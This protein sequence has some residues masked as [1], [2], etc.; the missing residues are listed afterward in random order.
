MN[1]TGIEFL[2]IKTDSIK[3]GM[4]VWDDKGYNMKTNSLIDGKLSNHKICPINISNCQLFGKL[5]SPQHCL[6]F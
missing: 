3:F 5:N 2:L 1:L 6:Y 4:I